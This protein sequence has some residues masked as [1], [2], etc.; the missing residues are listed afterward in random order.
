M[1]NLLSNF[2]W[3]VLAC[4]VEMMIYAEMVYRLHFCSL[5]V[6]RNKFNT[7]KRQKKKKNAA[8]Y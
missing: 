7:V 5:S 3:S 8:G 2:A 1:L 4:V 6:F